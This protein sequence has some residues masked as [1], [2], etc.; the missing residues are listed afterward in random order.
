MIYD[1]RQAAFRGS[2]RTFFRD[3]VLPDYPAWEDTGLPPRWFW[4][5]AGEL[6]ILGIG[7][8]AEYGGVQGAT[9]KDSAIVTEEAQRAGLAR[10][11]LRLHALA[12][13]L[14]QRHAAWFASRD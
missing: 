13:R 11:G 4:T 2:V 14:G 7:V 5:R 8:P 9:F 3:E 12:P 1:Q 6:G 10:G